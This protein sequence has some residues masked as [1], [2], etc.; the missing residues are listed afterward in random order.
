[1]LNK[2]GIEKIDYGFIS[3]VD[4]DH[5]RG[6]IS[7][8]EDN[9]I[10]FIYKPKLDST[11]V[12]DIELEKYLREKKVPYKYFSKEIIPVGN[13]R[14]Y[15]LNDT[16]KSY[17]A[18]QSFNDKSGMLKL[19]YGKC[20]FLFTGDA[21]INIEKEYVNQYGL[22]MKSDLLKA[23]HHG[24]KNSS[25]REFLKAVQPNYALISAGIGNKFHHP[26]KIVV[27]KLNEMRINVFRTD[28]EG[29]I[30]LQ[31]DGRTISKINWKNKETVFNF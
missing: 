16:T 20:S 18:Q 25:S 26:N 24:S 3:H 8:I 13:S 1:M 10:S 4:S 2:L 19:V 7:L 31:S 29:A 6:F 11:L 27:D 30:L 22:F 12:K 28:K 17:F 21:G 15:V 9:R 14:I 23:G 5:Y